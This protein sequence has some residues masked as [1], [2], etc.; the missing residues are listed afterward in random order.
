VAVA[1]DGGD[2]TDTVNYAGTSAA[3]MIGIAPDGGAIATFASGIQSSL[4]LTTNVENLTVAGAGGDDT[5]VAQNGLAGLAGLTKLTI[6]GGDGNDTLTGGDG[7]DTVIGGAGNDVVSGGRGNDTVLLGSGTDTFLWNPGDSSDTVEGGSGSDAIDFNGSN[8]DE[9]I[10]LAANGSRV[11]LGRDIAAV[12]LDLNGLEALNLS[13]R[14]GADTITVNDL[15][16]TNLSQVNIDLAGLP[17]TGVGDGQPDTIIA[18]GSAGP[19]H[20]I[21]GVTGSDVTLTGLGER[22]DVAG[23]DGPSDTLV[24]NTLGAADTATVAPAVGQLITPIVDL[25]ADQ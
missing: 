14:A 11:R 20:A 1:I 3:D 13:A 16:G 19:D 25:G 22:L 12:S 21:A 9:H 23:S 7:N 15:A 2:G 8:I 24:I 17:Q 10:D 5:I 6:N 4:Q 18:N